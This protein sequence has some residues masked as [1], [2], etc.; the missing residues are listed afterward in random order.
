[1]SRPLGASDL[2]L[3][4]GTVRTATE[5]TEASGNGDREVTERPPGG[6]DG[7]RD[8]DAVPP[9][10]AGRDGGSPPAAVPAPPVWPGGRATLAVIDH[11]PGI[12]AENIPH[13][14]ERFWREDQ[15]RHRARGG[16]GLGL[17]IVAAVVWAH[18]GQVTVRE[19]P[20]GGATFLVELP[21]S[22]AAPPPPESPPLGSS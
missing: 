17:S 8:G 16:S 18:G 1:L 19:T 12:P 4:E 20:G 13:V 22:S 14:F 10:G 9:P 21:A 15:S 7:Q 5:E 3:A 11:G 6:G 2:V